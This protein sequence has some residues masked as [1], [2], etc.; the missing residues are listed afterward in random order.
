VTAQGQSMMGVYKMGEIY[1]DHG[2]HVASATYAV[3]P[4]A[5]GHGVGRMTTNAP[6]MALF[7]GL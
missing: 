3:A 4:Q 7:R 6:A 2:S 1:P 5:Q